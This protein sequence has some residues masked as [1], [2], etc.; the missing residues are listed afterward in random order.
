MRNFHCTTDIDGRKESLSFGPKGKTGQMM[1]D[2]HVN[3]NGESRSVV[4]I[5]CIPNKNGE[6]C[7]DIFVD[8]H[9]DPYPIELYFN[10]KETKP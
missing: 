10:K 8:G 5:Y 9:H 6:L 4:R 3:D 2:L 7:I 1:L